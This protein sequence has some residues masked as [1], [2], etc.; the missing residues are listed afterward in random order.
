MIRKGIIIEHFL[1]LIFSCVSL[2]MHSFL[3]FGERAGEADSLII[4]S[5]EAE[6]NGS[7][8]TLNGNVRVEH[9]LGILSGRHITLTPAKDKKNS[10]GLLILD[11]DVVVDFSQG[12]QL[13]CQKAEINYQKLS[14]NFSGNVQHPDVI[15]REKKSLDKSKKNSI[16]LKSKTVDVD[17]MSASSEGQSKKIFL[18]QIKAD[19]N[20]KAYYDDDYMVFCDFATYNPIQNG[21]TGI[22]SLGMANSGN[23]S[24]LLMTQNQDHI[25]AKDVLIDTQKRQLACSHPRGTLI[26][27]KEQ[28][29]L[30]SSDKMIIDETKQMLS[31]QQAVK[32]N[33]GSQVDLST[34]KE[35]EIHRD[36]INGKKVLTK[37]FSPEETLITYLEQ[38]KIL[39]HRL[40]CY[41]ALTID[42]DLL[43]ATLKSPVNS[44]GFTIEGKQ[45]SFED[46]LG[47]IQ[48]DVVVIIYQQIDRKL[49]PSKIILSG[50]V[51]IFN[52]FDGH[53]QESGSVL[54]YA[55][56]DVVEYDPFSKEMLLRSGEGKRVLLFD[57]VN[58]IQM[59][60]PALK[61]IRDEAHPKG[62]IKGIGDVR[63]TFIE[64]E[65]EQLRKNFKLSDKTKK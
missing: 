11:E 5:G 14:G 6:Y 23:T 36:E 62:S 28:I 4:H 19:D 13:T 16:L 7:E 20:V 31:L 37:I 56:A 2:F 1:K 8:V 24:C 26:F 21:S 60:A 57:K 35:I 17:L 41:G 47:R 59:S 18:K 48:A 22:L 63:F 58:N 61:I 10:L 44:Q 34:N 64:K 33:L 46:L 53:V 52:C 25:Q 9:S 54:Q 42:H 15:Y 30:F 55:L 49:I 38:N 50:D 40:F 29:L 65:F 3:L 51:K 27:N 45:V 32:V 39:E 12:G 43:Q